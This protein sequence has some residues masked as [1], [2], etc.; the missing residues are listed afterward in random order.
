NNEK[1]KIWEQ[2]WTLRYRASNHFKQEVNFKFKSNKRFSAASTMRNRDVSG[3]GVGTRSIFRIM[4]GMDNSLEVIGFLEE[5]SREGGSLKEHYIKLKER[6][7]ALV[8]KKGRLTAIFQ[9]Y[10]VVIDK[11]PLN[12]PLP[13]E[14]AEG[15]KEGDSMEWSLRMD[16]FVSNNL[17]FT[18]NYRG[19]K[20]PIYIKTLHTGLMELRAFF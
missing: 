4:K 1:R 8:L 9:W 16:Y 20:D 5:D 12:L 11:N 17:T 19:R 7:T 15:K 10:K 6:L 14:M 3:Y 13:Y 2:E 18:F